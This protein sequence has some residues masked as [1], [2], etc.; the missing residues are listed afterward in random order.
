MKIVLTEEIIDIAQSCKGGWSKEQFELI[1]VEWPPVKGWK[2][3]VIGKEFD[4]LILND[5]VQLKNRHFSKKKNKEEK[6]T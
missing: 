4:Y 1:G 6:N 3:L 2:S 5:F